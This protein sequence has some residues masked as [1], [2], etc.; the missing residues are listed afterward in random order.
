MLVSAVYPKRCCVLLTHVLVVRPLLHAGDA[1]TLVIHPAS[2]THN[3][4]TPEEQLNSGVTPDLVRI[5]VGIEDIEDIIADFDA[6]FR[7][8]F[9]SQSQ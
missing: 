9:E 2:S 7:I 4:L 5:S 1:K 6:A 8:V 3:Q